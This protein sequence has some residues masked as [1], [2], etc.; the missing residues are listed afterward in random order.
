M[1]MLK[2]MT[3]RGMRK[4]RISCCVGILLDDLRRSIEKCRVCRKEKRLGAGSP[5]GVGDDVGDQAL[6][7]PDRRWML[8]TQVDQE[9]SDLM[10]VENF[11]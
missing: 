8:Y 9:G 11:R 7:S 2:P 3:T 4:K 10:L 5:Q 1:R 6:P